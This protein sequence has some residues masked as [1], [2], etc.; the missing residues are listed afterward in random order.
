MSTPLDFWINGN[1][2]GLSYEEQMELIQ[3]SIALDIAWRCALK[4]AKEVQKEKGD[5]SYGT[6]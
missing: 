4:T 1:S 5:K 2:E 6:R 3:L